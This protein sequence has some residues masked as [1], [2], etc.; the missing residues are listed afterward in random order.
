[1][2]MKD[3]TTKEQR[4]GGFKN[5]KQAQSFR[6]WGMIITVAVASFLLGVTVQGLLTLKYL[7]G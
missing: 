4:L 2:Y 7:L 3:Y 5:E 1:M 6:D